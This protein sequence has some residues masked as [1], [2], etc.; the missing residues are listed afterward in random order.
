MADKKIGEL[1][2]APSVYDDSLF[3]VEQQGQ[4]VK[5]TGRQWKS[6]AQQAVQSQTDAAQTAAKKAEDAQNA[7]ENMTVRANALPSGSAASVQKTTSGGVVN[8]TFG[9]PRGEK[10]DRGADG[11]D[12]LPGE[13]GDKGDK[14][15]KGEKG[16]DGAPGQLLYAVF[17]LDVSDGNLYM[18]TDERYS[19]PLFR[20]NQSDLEVVL[21][22]EG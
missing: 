3:V 7:I 10:G 22:Y 15:D 6:F 5:A 13:K 1:P 9:L 8:L 16:D 4:A 20:L 11:N 12:G 2:A 21:N 14:G 17:C 18:V 19:G